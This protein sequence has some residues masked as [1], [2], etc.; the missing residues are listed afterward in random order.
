MSADAEV[1]RDIIRSL[2]QILRKTADSSRSLSRDVGL[3]LPQLLT[4]R[5]IHSL[6]AERA[7]VAAVATELRLTPGTTSR[8]I[9]RLVRADIVRRERS[10]IDRRRVVLTLTPEG[11]RRHASVPI[12]LQEL[13]A[14]NLGD[15]P[16]ERGVELRNAMRTL[17]TLLGADSLD[18][19]PILD[20]EA[21]P[22][23]DE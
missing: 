14:R 22:G 17:V 19:A 6:G 16:P 15:L 1:A 9:E 12:P 2:R 5:A 4:I 8:I 18:V 23:R 20:G 3:T 21:D 7:T 10:T 13:L 11:E